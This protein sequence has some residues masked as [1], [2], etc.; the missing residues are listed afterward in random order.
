MK[1]IK[2]W[3]TPPPVVVEKRWDKF[4]V[5][6]WHHRMVAAEESGLKNIDAIVIEKPL[7]KWNDKKFISFSEKWIENLTKK[8]EYF[9]KS[10]TIK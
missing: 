1:R 4:Y 6:D 5:W 8:L 10:K 9:Y 7:E 2:E 3:D